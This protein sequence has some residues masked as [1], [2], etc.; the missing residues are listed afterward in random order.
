MKGNQEMIPRQHSKEL[1]FNIALNAIQSKLT[2]AEIVTKYSLNE[3]LVHKW[4]KQLL[5]QGSNILYKDERSQKYDKG[6][7]LNVWVTY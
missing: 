5:D 1:K 3:S 6:E 2:I 7:H 4:K